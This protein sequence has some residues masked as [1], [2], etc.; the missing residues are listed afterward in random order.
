[1]ST[2]ATIK[3]FLKN[4]D[5]KRLR[6]AEI[7]N[8]SGK[9]IAAPRSDLEELL[10]REELTSTGVYILLGVDPEDGKPVAYIGEAEV[11]VERLRQHRTKDYWNSAIIFVSLNSS[12]TKAHVK[13]MEGEL[14]SRAKQI[15]RLK[16]MNN[17]ASGARLPESD[18]HDM[19]TFLD[20]VAQ[21]L[22][23]LGSDLLTEIGAPGI[24]TI[25]TLTCS[26]KGATAKGK[27]VPNGFVV[28]RDSTA[29][30]ED[31][32]SAKSQS[33]WTIGLRNRLKEEGSLIERDGFL[34]F[35]K[36]VE[37]SSPSAAAAVVCGGSVAGP[38][39]WKDSS[40]KTLKELEEAQA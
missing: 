31:R 33:P 26:I 24:K 23:I 27:R 13:Y 16:I 10:A 38:L 17:Q 21:L 30:V 14:I 22:P 12:L 19:A 39:A 34:V 20:R 6:T 15:G 3:L 5:P 35:V 36:D 4:G 28:L 8:W 7:S 37:F 9:A 2:A 18:I 32:A 11:V 29:V 1:M 25:P 40:G